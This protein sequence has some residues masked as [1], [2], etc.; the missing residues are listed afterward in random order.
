LI[1]DLIGTTEAAEIL[2]LSTGRV[3][4]L[5]KEGR[6]P[7]S[8]VVLG[9]MMVPRKEVE[10]F[11]MQERRPGRRPKTGESGSLGGCVMAAY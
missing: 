4:V 3:R 2:G 6:F 10:A 8:R 5:I 1:E 7:G 11:K 9:R